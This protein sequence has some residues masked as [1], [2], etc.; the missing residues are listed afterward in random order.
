MNIEVEIKNTYRDHLNNFYVRNA[1]LEGF[2]TTLIVDKTTSLVKVAC[3]AFDEKT[4]SFKSFNFETLNDD[5]RTIKNVDLRSVLKKSDD[6]SIIAKEAIDLFEA[7]SRC[8]QNCRQM[9]LSIN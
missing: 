1:I 6:N 2:Q 3:L 5:F 8:W 9:L 4:K 7:E